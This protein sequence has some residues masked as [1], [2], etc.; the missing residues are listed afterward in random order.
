MPGLV[1]GG[2]TG[3]NRTEAV[4][5]MTAWLAGNDASAPLTLGGLELTSVPDALP[6]SLEQ[7]DG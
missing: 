4:R 5:R 7:L 6:D 3:G 2:A 1:P